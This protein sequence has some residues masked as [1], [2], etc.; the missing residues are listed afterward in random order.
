[1]SYHLSTD[2]TW[3]TGQSS[4]H[5]RAGLAPVNPKINGS[6]TVHAYFTVYVYVNACT[7]IGMCMHVSNRVCAC[8][9]QTGY[10]HTHTK[11]GICTPI[12]KQVCARPYQNRYV[13]ANT[14]TGMCMPIPKQACAR[15]YQN[16][17]VHACIKSGM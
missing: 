10:V 3:T 14:K 7:K 8:T 5:C 13:H 6:I 2:L 17:Y 11:T 12:P 4:P 15:P 1:M 16:R 9:F